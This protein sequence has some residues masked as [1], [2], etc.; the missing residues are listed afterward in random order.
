MR[1]TILAVAVIAL[2]ACGK[3]SNEKSENKSDKT[4]VE[5]KTPDKPT[6]KPAEDAFTN[7]LAFPAPIAKLA[8]GMT[9]ADAKAAVPDLQP[10]KFVEAPDYEGLETFVRI[11]DGRVAQVSAAIKKQPCDAVQAWLTKKWGAPLELTNSS[12]KKLAHYD[13]A[14]AGL[15]AM[16]EERGGGSCQLNYARV[17]TTEQL[18]GT[19]PKLFGFEKTALIG[20][21]QE[22]LMKT[23]ADAMPKPRAD[24]PN[25]ITISLPALTT[26]EYANHADVRLK[27]GKVTGYTLSIV[28]GGD[29]ATDAAIAARLEAMFGKGKKASLYTDY[30]GPPKVKA[31]LR[32]KDSA[33]FPHTIWVGDYK[34]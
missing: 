1:I 30:P 25:S 18:L 22:D 28:S 5:T 17:A 16:V 21:T 10:E 19:D 27:D 9:E 34:K 29:A 15:R 24:D 2:A 6:K 31:E 12:G 8:I 26:S 7:T 23:Y 20:M 3:K 11:T 14:T 33:S 4:S 32:E 13:S